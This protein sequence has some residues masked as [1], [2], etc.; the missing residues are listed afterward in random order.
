M[1]LTQPYSVMD[2]IRVGSNDFDIAFK[3]DT[4]YLCSKSAT[5]DILS[6][7]FDTW[8]RTK[9]LR[10]DLLT[11]IDF[12]LSRKVD[13]ADVGAGIMGLAYIE[14]RTTRLMGSDVGYAD[15]ELPTKEF[16]EIVLKWIDFLESHGK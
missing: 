14:Y 1:K 11:E 4:Y 15:M 13:F 16:K 12:V 2:T 9:D 10:E 7:F 3:G 6:G 5:K 8:R